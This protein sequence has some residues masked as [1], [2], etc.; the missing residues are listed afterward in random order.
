M[1]IS[2]DRNSSIQYPKISQTPAA[3]SRARFLLNAHYAKIYGPEIRRE[4]CRSIRVKITQIQ[5]YMTHVRHRQPVLYLTLARQCVDF[6]R[7][8]ALLEVLE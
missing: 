2:L 1:G 5:T 4:N 8:C 6:E 7:V 3:R